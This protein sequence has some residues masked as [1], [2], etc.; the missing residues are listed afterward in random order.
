[1]PA[2]ILPLVLGGS[3]CLVA[4]AYVGYPLLIWMISRCCGRHATPPDRSERAT[5]ADV[6]VVIAA[7]NE[8][9]VIGERIENLLAADYPS[10]RLRMVVGSD[11]SVDATESIVQ[12]WAKRHPTQVQLFDFQ[13]RRG[14][15]AV[16]N[17]LLSRV[18]GDIVVFS[19]ANTHF[20]KPAIARL[21]RW[22]DDPTVGAVCGRLI[23][24]DPESGRNVDGLYWKYETFLKRCEARLGALLGANGAIYAIRRD[25]YVPI[26]DDTIIDDFT[27]P[28]LIKLRHG[29]HLIYDETAIA[30]E[31]SAPDVGS[32]FRRRCRIGAGNFQALPRLWPLLLPRH[33][34]TSFAFWS[35]KLLRWSCPLFMLTAFL[36]N[37]ALLR[38]PF[39]QGLFAAQLAFYLSALAGVWIPAGRGSFRVFRLATLFASVNLA[40]GCGFVR[41]L[42]GGQRGTWQRTAR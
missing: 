2:L 37:L 15:A 35:H 13:E 27:I 22:F 26:A 14:K 39:F 42:R 17:D 19:D 23:M 28:L 6:A 18:E 16:L 25:E 24:V 1:M 4:Y 31:D 8:Q 9:D 41:Y 21:A 40:L 7:L 3:I 33:G 12:R 11:G 5:P 29:K 30:R 32:E 34:W 10:D 20:D 36:A 38:Q